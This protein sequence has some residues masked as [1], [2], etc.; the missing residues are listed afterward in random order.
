[1]NT[2]YLKITGPIPQGVFFLG[3]NKKKKKKKKKKWIARTG[4]G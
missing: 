2:Y 3:K 4:L 1:M